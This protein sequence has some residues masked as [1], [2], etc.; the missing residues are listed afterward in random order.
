[1]PPERTNNYYCHTCKEPTKQ[2]ELGYMTNSTKEVQCL[3]CLRKNI[4]FVYVDPTE[5]SE[6]K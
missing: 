1:M 3:T 2:I 4:V 6:L 5:P